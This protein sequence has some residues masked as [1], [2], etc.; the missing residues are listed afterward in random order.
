MEN[1]KNYDD[2]LLE[3]RTLNQGANL[4]TKDDITNNEITF[5]GGDGP[6]AGAIDLT[7]TKKEEPLKKFYGNTA[8]EEQKKRK[9]KHKRRSKIDRVLSLGKNL[10]NSD[11]NITQ[12]NKSNN[13]GG[14]GASYPTLGF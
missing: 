7:K 1:I 12:T 4:S 14:G 2:F 5:D 9:K 3:L 13:S 6:S 10:N 11:Q 8:R